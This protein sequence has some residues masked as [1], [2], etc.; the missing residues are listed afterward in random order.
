MALTDAQ[1]AALMAD[2]EFTG[3]VKVSAIR[4]ADTLTI[5]AVPASSHIR[6]L[7]YAAETFQSP[8]AMAQKLVPLVVMDAAV[9]D[10]GA[11]ITDEALQGAVESTVNKLYS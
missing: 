1:S 3:R 5:Q 9:Q 7:A 11:M 8:A 2:T 10:A 6:L 4:Y